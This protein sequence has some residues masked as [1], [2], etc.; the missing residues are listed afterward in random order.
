MTPLDDPGPLDTE[1][2]AFQNYV[3]QHWR[4]EV[5][6][7]TTQPPPAPPAEEE[8]PAAPARPD[9]HGGARPGPVGEDMGAVD[10]YIS[11]FFPQTR[12]Q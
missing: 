7:S 11:R 8:P 5:A 10:D 9:L 2:R 4:T 6:P 1:E 12:R 3:R